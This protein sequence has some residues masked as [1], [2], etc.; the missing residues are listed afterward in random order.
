METINGSEA[1]L[2]S[3]VNK[4]PIVVIDIFSHWCPPCK[5]LAPIL[6]QLDKELDPKEVKI[7]KVDVTEGA[8]QFVKDMGIKMVPTLLYFNNGELKLK[9]TG[10]KDKLALLTN[11]ESVKK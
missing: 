1:D 11:I 5:Q 7:F 3:L 8:P 9:E 6:E 10:F 4:A 2:G